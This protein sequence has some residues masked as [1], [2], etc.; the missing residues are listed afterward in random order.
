[1]ELARAARRFAEEHL[2]LDASV[3][4]YEEL[5]ESVLQGHSVRLTAPTPQLD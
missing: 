5:Y 2:D 1:V 4:A 3:R